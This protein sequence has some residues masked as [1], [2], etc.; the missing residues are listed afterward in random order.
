MNNIKELIRDL[1]W[2]KPKEFQKMAIEQLL[3]I[4]DSELV[5]LAQQ[6]ELC[7]KYCWHNAAIVLKAIGYPRIKTV[8][9]YL[10]EWFQD[11]NWPGVKTITEIFRG[12]EPL[13]LLPYIDDVSKRAIFDKDE[14]WAFGIIRL[15]R[16]IGLEY[17][18]NEDLHEELI[19]L[20]GL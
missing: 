6:N 1:D 3:E 8:I 7:K 14:M 9:P 13:E 16:D 17:L 15:L 2:S 20:S 10:M 4:D 18:I 19:K 12:I 5:F 11:T